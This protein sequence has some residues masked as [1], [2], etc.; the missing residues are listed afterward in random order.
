MGKTGALYLAVDQLRASKADRDIFDEFKS[1][2]EAMQL[3]I[4]DEVDSFQS[5]TL[6]CCN[7]MEKYIP[8]YILRQMTEFLEYLHTDRPMRWRI[9]WYN[10][11]KVPMLTSAIL[12]DNGEQSL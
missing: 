3:Q 12:F 2:S 1:R 6:S 8:L 10:E 4:R 11:V 9:N 5:K 7:Y